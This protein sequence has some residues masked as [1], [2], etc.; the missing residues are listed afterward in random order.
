MLITRVLI[1]LV[2]IMFSLIINKIN[3]KIFKTIKNYTFHKSFN[4]IKV[5]KISKKIIGKD[6]FYV[7]TKEENTSKVLDLDEINSHSTKYFD[8]EKFKVSK[9]LPV[10]SISSGV[11]I[12]IG[13]KEN[14]N[15]TIIIQGVDNYNIW[16]GNIENIN[17]RL[18]DYVEQGSLIGSCITDE[19]Y[20]LIEKDGKLFTY[21]EYKKNISN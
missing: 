3:P 21:D 4:F 14:F 16:Y 11:V 6:V 20:L 2:I 13:K 7:D 17:Y 15:N 5:N 9:N 19:I 18:Y 8:G 1:S 12:F 10:G